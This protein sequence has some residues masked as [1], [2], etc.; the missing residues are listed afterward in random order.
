MYPENLIR[1]D[2]HSHILPKMDD[3]SKSSSESL[4]MLEKLF[5]D[6]VISVVATP[7]FYP[8]ED[9]PKAFFERR[10]AS[11]ARLYEVMRENE[12]K[13]FPIVY[14]GAEVGFYRGLSTYKDLP[15]LC[16]VGTDHIL[17]E[18]PFERWSRTMVEEVIFMKK[19]RGVT[20][21]I[22]HIERYF[23]YID[24]SMLDAL[25]EAGCVIQCNVEPLLK[26]FSRRK[27]LDLIK[28]ERIHVL[29]SDSHNMTSRAPRVAEATALLK[30]KL[31]ERVVDVFNHNARG[32][33]EGALELAEIVE[34]ETL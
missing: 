30:D 20:P 11:C 29:G 10:A 21:V 34:G 22:A 8:W 17:I 25:I 23:S 28:R 9:E 3:G 16:I 26:F 4:E 13:Q 14:V 7:H 27:V 6:G 31:G 15:D 19:T 24:E 32:V 5:A 1:F 33:L 12:E 2:L 18:M